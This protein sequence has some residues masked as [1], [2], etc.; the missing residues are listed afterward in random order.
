MILI[1]EL[2]ALLQPGQCWDATLGNILCMFR[3][4]RLILDI[5]IF[6]FLNSEFCLIL[7][8]NP[9]LGSLCF[10]I[11]LFSLT[12]KRE[13]LDTI[14]MMVISLNYAIKAWR[15]VCTWK[16]DMSVF[17]KLRGSPWEER[18]FRGNKKPLSSCFYRTGH[19]TR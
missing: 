8:W 11:R 3:L 17:I 19:L 2:C 9:V 7:I 14:L 12:I 6:F 5:F 1:Q 15:K 18:G 13:R 4:S 10:L 16:L